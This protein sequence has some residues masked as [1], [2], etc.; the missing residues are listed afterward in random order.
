MNNTYILNR[1]TG[2][3]ELHF[4]KSKYDAL[5][6]DK[7]SL[8]KSNFLFSGKLKAWV[9]RAKFPNLYSAKRA[10]AELGFTEEEKVGERLSYAEQV[11]QQSERAEAR[12]DRYLGYAENAE[13]RGA[14]LQKELNDRRGDIAFF[15]QPII[16]GHSGSESFAKRRQRI[17][18]RY[19]KGMEEYRKSEYFRDKA[20]TAMATADN[21]KVKDPT[22]LNNRIKECES[23]IKKLRKNIAYYESIL[24]RLEDPDSAESKSDRYTSEKVNGWLEDTLEM[25]DIQVD[26]LGYFQNCVEA[27]GGFKFSKENIKPGYVVKI[28]NNCQFKIL[29]ANPKTVLARCLSTDMILTYDYAEI[30]EIVSAVE[31]KPKEK[32][33]PHP[34]QKDDILV[35]NP[36]GGSRPIYAYQIVGVTEKSVQIR[37]IKQLEN[38][39]H[40]KDE[41]FENSKPLR[42]TPKVRFYSGTWFVTGERDCVLEKYVEDKGEA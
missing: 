8:L 27:L 39:K 29:K 4:E 28:R 25:L 3:I 6:A 23:S 9:S 35:W 19:D 22:Y 12:A 41:F 38:G 10:A 16:A 34:Y 30:K 33:E 5:P 13:K 15:T 24:V 1:K 37:R 21:S 14:E 11:A 2:K 40:L 42:R 18:D 7:K 17:Y 32:S 31:E 26:K 20:A 36:H